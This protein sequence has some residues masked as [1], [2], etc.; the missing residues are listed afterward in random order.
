MVLGTGIQGQGIGPS[1]RFIAVIG[2]TLLIDATS[3]VHADFVTARAR[4]TINP[5]VIRAAATD[6]VMTDKGVIVWAPAHAVFC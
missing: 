5:G 1:N 6:A 3:Q 2:I 4:G